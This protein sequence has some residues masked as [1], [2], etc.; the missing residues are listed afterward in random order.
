MQLRGDIQPCISSQFKTDLIRVDISEIVDKGK[1]KLH[2]F[3][4]KSRDSAV[5]F[6]RAIELISEGAESQDSL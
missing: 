2:F 1:T 5:E 4:L 3:Y 6:H